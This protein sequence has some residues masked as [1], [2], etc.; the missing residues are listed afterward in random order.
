[1]STD[2]YAHWRAGLE[3]KVLPMTEADVGL[4]FFYTRKIKNGPRIPVAI[5][6]DNGETIAL[7]GDEMITGDDVMAVWI[8]CAKRCIPEATYRARVETGEWPDDV[9]V[10]EAAALSNLPSDPFERLKV[11]IKEYAA[12]AA[13]TGSIEDDTASDKAA[14]LRNRLL[15]LGKK[16]DSMRE[17][18]KRPHL[19]AGRV[20]DEKYRSLLDTARDACV[21]LRNT[22]TIYLNAKQAALNKKA[23]EEAA[24]LKAVAEAAAAVAGNNDVPTEVIAV[25]QRATAGGGYGK[26]AGLRTQTSV[27]I[28]DYPKA[29]AFLAENE[30]VREAVLK[31]ATALIKSGVSVPGAE[32]K[33]AQVAA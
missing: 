19:E 29:L 26:R 8:G 17:A 7:V 1:M 10:P 33:T 13:Q 6:E 2:R 20:V 4:G 12:L 22:L 5:F 11:E 25:P 15:E 16:A 18:E 14:N 3:G 27:V 9:V 23:E 30:L 28:T 32:K 31:A 21:S 24:K